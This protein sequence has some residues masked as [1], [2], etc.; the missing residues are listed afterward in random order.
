MTI[1]CDGKLFLT[2]SYN[3]TS[4]YSNWI[5]SYELTWKQLIV[6]TVMQMQPI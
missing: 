3:C 1:Y 6:L 2:D 4:V 5:L